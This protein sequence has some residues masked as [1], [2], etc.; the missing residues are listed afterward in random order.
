MTKRFRFIAPRSSGAR[1]GG[2]A[3][4]ACLL[5]LLNQVAGQKRLAAAGDGGATFA[6]QSQ[7]V[8]V[9][10]TVT[11]GSRRISDLVA[12][13]FSLAEDNK[14]QAIDRVDTGTVPLQVALLLDTSESMREALPAVQAAAEFFVQSLQPEDRVTLI[15]FNSDVRS[16]PQ[17]TDDQG[18]LLTAI[19]SLKAA[20]STRLYDALLYAAKQL[21]G[22][23]GRK[24]IV[25]FSDGEDTGRGS[26]LNVVLNASARYGFP[27][28]PI[29]AGSSLVREQLRR[30]L[31]DLADVNGARMFLLEKPEDLQGAFAEIS[32]ELRSAYVLSYYTRVPFDGGWHNL[33]VSV[34]NPRVKVNSRKGFFA[35]AGASTGLM[36]ALEPPRELPRAAADRPAPPPRDLSAQ[37]AFHELTSTPAPLREVNATGLRS[38]KPAAARAAV[39]QQRPSFKVESRFVEV[40]VLM[41]AAA[42][43][44]LPDLLE[45]DFRI[46]EDGALREVGY[47]RRGIRAEDLPAVR[48]TALKNAFSGSSTPALADARDL[49]LG[50]TYV[51]VDNVASAPGA[52]IGARDAAERLIREYHS[53]VRP[54][55]L[56]LTSEGQASVTAGESVEQMIR[57][58][59]SAGVRSDRELTSNDGIMSIHEAYLIERGDDQARQLVELRYASQQRVHYKNNLGEVD[60]TE[61]GDPTMIQTG[62]QVLCRTL[63]GQN[64]SQTSRMLDGLGAVLNAAVA[65][66]GTY[67]K[68]IIF[69]SSGFSVG[70]TSM[71]SDLSSRLDSMVRTAR[72]HHVRFL[73]VSASGLET[74]EAIGIGA[75]GAFLLRNPHL[76][77]ILNSHASDW[78][79][80]RE[81]PLAQLANETGGRF[82]HSTNDLAGA[83]ATALRGTGQLYYL[84]FL[85]SQPADGRFHRIRVVTSAVATIHA[86]KGYYAGRR[87]DQGAGAA[88]DEDLQTLLLRSDE[89]RRAG[90]IEG[91]ASALRALV[92]KVPDNPGLWFNLGSTLTTI[93]DREGAVDALRKAL[94]LAPDD[95]MV[96]AALAR[97]LVAAGYREAAAETLTNLSQKHPGSI[98][99]L[100]ELGRVLEADSRLQDAYQAYRSVLDLTSSPPLDVYVLLARTSVRLGRTTETRLFIKDYLA[101]GGQEKTIE[102]WRRALNAAHPL[103]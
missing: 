60:G 93:D 48:A 99:L 95:R 5:P 12:S 34:P 55:S 84:G 42:G 96:G 90:D 29:A 19:R 102:Q 9:Y 54:A 46:Y 10:A 49:V 16:V 70:R 22:K 4:L 35:R 45:K 79:S 44:T 23:E 50:R 8:Q 15:P 63:L 52:F 66:P 64:F 98:D 43:R 89:A 88:G 81:T 40:P 94:E 75:S 61:A 103:P 11:E 26:S 51:V 3:V 25:T 6:V 53:A 86:R 38:E 36:S 74:Q 13:D 33:A 68:T 27:I 7:L 67:P 83:A 37:V 14:P 87:A 56:H 71:R 97:A 57:R 100:V 17:V 21:S 58:L 69:F 78:R 31:K 65:D 91:F 41:E 80:D 1:L 82:I 59:R 2:L 76:T 32:A 72:E 101:R 73:T 28:Y 39:A 47:F 30:V 20:G 77:G 62:V 24:A 85:S 18:P 92:G